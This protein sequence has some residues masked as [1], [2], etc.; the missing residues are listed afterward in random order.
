MKSKLSLRALKRGACIA[1][2][3]IAL[4]ACSSDSAS[5]AQQGDEGAQ[6]SSSSESDEVFITDPDRSGDL[7]LKIPEDFPYP[8]VPADNLLSHAKAELGRQLFFDTKLSITMTRSC[9]HCHQ[10]ALAFTDGLEVSVGIDELEIHTRNAMSLTNVAYNAG[11]NWAN[12]NVIDLEGQAHGVLFNETPVELGWVD[13]EEE[14]LMRLREDE[15]YLDMFALA[16]ED[17]GEEL[18]SVENTIKALASFQRT[19]ISTNAPF[20]QFNR[21]DKSALNGSAKRG[22]DLFFSEQLECFHCHGGFNLS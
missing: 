9:G 2:L 18:I 22:M 11:F 4:T 16:F 6:G 8:D 3:L 14:I 13:N 19:M 7:T 5:N 12:P 1:P 17:N 20:D 10:P 21:G 15:L